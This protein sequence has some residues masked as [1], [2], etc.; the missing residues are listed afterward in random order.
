VT[1]VTTFESRLHVAWQDLTA[2][3][4]ADLE[5]AFADLKAQIAQFKPL[6]QTFE[7]DT[8]AALAGKDPNIEVTVT[9]LVEKPLADAAKI[10]VIAA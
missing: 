1:A 8:K 3:A 2:E 9:R 6:L 4:R 7:A 5:Q 10:G